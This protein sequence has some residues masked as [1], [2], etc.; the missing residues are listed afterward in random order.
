VPRGQHLPREDEKAVYDRHENEV[1]DQRYRGFLDRL[2]G[3]LLERLQPPGEVLEFGCGHGPAL[4]AMLGE[5]G[6][7]VS[8]Y[9]PFY[10]PD[11]EVFNRRYDAITATEV[12]EHLAAPGRELGRLWGCLRKGGWLGVMTK[13]QPPLD[14]FATWHYRYD[15]THVS[16][17]H[18]ESF[19]WL[20]RQWE[21]NLV[22]PRAD[23]VLL[24]KPLG[25]QV[26]S[27]PPLIHW[28]GRKAP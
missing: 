27:A 26:R 9:D 11:P 14:Q 1:D 16:L 19:Y 5:V 3:P 6:F 10:F 2:A 15:P 24:G 23:V 20:A 12:V 25:S 21:A 8:L 7:T 18:A 22:M 17:F 13:R 4:A 28:P